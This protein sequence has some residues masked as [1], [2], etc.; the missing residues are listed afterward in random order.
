MNYEGEMS[1]RGY[2]DW[3]AEPSRA[4]GWFV[5]HDAALSRQA[6]REGRAE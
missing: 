5:V 4:G 3:V 1:W 2:A 6:F